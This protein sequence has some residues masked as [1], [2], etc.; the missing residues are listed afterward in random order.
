MRTSLILVILFTIITGSDVFAVDREIYGKIGTGYASD[1]SRYGLDLAFQYNYVL[2]PYFVVGPEVGFFWLKWNR[3]IGVEQVSPGI[4][5]D[6]AADT[7][8]YDVPL[9]LNATV[10]IPNLSS[11]VKVAPFVTVGLGYSFMLINY[12]QPTFTDAAT[13]E[14]YESDSVTKFFH[15]FTWQLVFGVGYQP[16]RSKVEFSVEAGYRGSTLEYESLEIDMS[17]FVFRVGAR[18]PL[19][20]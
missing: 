19:G 15:G 8:A 20:G 11:T 3:T 17:G 18:Y 9:F 10:R 2:D 14:H 16:E 1:Q 13:G 12:S 7:N 4:R 5:A 6:V